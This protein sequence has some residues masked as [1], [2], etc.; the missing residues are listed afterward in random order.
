MPVTAQ[1]QLMTNHVPGVALSA[2][3]RL[4]T[5][6]SATHSPLLFALNSEHRLSLTLPSTTSSTGWEA[7]D[8]TASLTA[9]AELGSTPVVHSF[10]VSQ[11]PD[12]G[13]WLVLA[14]AAGAGR[15]S[16]VYVSKRMA[17]TESTQ[18]WST[19]AAGLTERRIPDNL[20]V[21][22]ILVGGDRG[23]TP[24]SV[25]VALD[26]QDRVEYHQINPDPAGSWSS[27]PVPLPQDATRCVAVAV[28]RHRDFGTG[29]YSLFELATL[30]SLVFTTLPVDFEG[31]LMFDTVELDLPAGLAAAALDTVANPDGTTD[32]YVGGDGVCRYSA[33]RQATSH[34][35]TENLMDSKHVSGVRDLVVATDQHGAQL[36]VWAI[37]RRDTLVYVEGSRPAAGGDYA[38]QQPLLLETEVTALSAYRVQVAAEH[39]RSSVAMALGGS[40]GGFRMLT[41]D[42]QTALWR[43]QT[44]SLHTRNE[45][46]PLQT[47]TTRVAVTDERGDPLRDKEILIEPD[48]DCAALVNS[49]YYALRAGTPKPATTDA[50]GVVTIVLETAD[51]SAPVY[52]FHVDGSVALTADPGADT[53][54]TLRGL[55]GDAIHDAKRNNGKPLLDTP[56]DAATRDK[57]A[58]AVGQ[59]MRAHD[60]L[61]RQ[62]SARTSTEAD[63]ATVSAEGIRDG[64]V[65]VGVGDLLTALRGEAR[66]VTDFLVRQIEDSAAWKFA[67]WVGD[68]MY[69]AVI[70]FAHQ[71]IAAIDWVLE[72]TLGI[73]LEDLID[74]LGFLFS[75]DDILANHRVL[76]KIVTLSFDHVTQELA[77]SKKSVDDWFGTVR[78]S[79]TDG[80]LVVDRSADIF[81]KRVGRDAAQ[82]SA[83]HQ[84][85]LDKPQTSWGTHQL[86]GNLGQATPG[87]Y[88]PEDPGDLLATVVDEEIAVFR[89]LGEQLRT[90]FAGGVGTLTLGE[91]VEA[92]AEMVGIAVVDTL[93]NMT[94]TV[95]DAGI[96]V[97]KAVEAMLTTRWD[98]PVL[99]P[100]YEKVI[101]RGDGSELTLVDLICLLGAI[102]ATIVG[103]AVLPDHANLFSSR[104]IEAVR[105]ATTWDAA[106]T[107]LSAQPA[108]L[109]AA[110]TPGVQAQAAKVLQLVNA[111]LRV[112][113]VY[114]S[115]PLDAGAL[116]PTGAATP[117]T[118]Q[119]AK[120]AL[121]WTG[122]VVGLV[123]MGL[124]TKKKRS[125]RENVDIAIT[126]LGIVPPAM[127]TIR[128]AAPPIVARGT[129]VTR[130]V[131]AG[132]GWVLLLLS[133][134]SFGMQVGEDHPGIDGAQYGALLGAKMT[135]NV[136]AACVAV[137]ADF[138]TPTVAEAQP[139]V[140][141]A[142]LVIRAAFATL[143]M[144]LQLARAVAQLAVSYTDFEGAVP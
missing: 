80:K 66:D 87:E 86:S 34:L 29:I 6:Y 118:L 78:G 103:K 133:C 18:D 15:P 45:V 116:D 9:R 30:H 7:L 60:D 1:S 140:F 56:P 73:S 27:T 31:E 92:V 102:P 109:A 99:T 23:S 62:K 47:Y 127:G 72:H 104:Q 24:F 106:V 89:Q 131:D 36:S 82:L 101:C 33:D 25:V 142:A 120:L 37:D 91:I 67:V 50:Q 58:N 115:I 76:T 88:V 53:K 38:W 55:T 75:W 22:D 17:N 90:L 68:Q 46:L 119:L 122:Y 114:L 84:K 59:L 107:A 113:N 144:E 61:S 10:A 126:V 21:T 71:A 85:A 96:L 63:A 79:F 28:G 134:V 5:V 43:H 130:V 123:G 26:E 4:H 57:A 141:G 129:E 11:D 12:G 69:E 40:D 70:E 138:M 97:V 136:S 8:L 74:W 111:L 39:D 35:P 3:R 44:V 51:L 137:L 49:R 143:R 2:Q 41:Q 65:D 13:I 19:L 125:D 132:Y 135:Q 117:R 128:V 124:L 20:T 105:T 98:I 121:D 52:T 54:E 94:L 139:E 95:I 48:R 112:P 81:A 110:A 16:R 93:E 108:R 77:A 64:W 100:L 42:P 83:E 32:L 14:A